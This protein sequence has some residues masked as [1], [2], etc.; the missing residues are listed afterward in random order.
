ML[1]IERHRRILESLEREGSARVVDLAREYEVTEETIRRDLDRLENAGRLQRSHGGA[2]PISGEERETPYWW[3]EVAHESEKVAMAQEAV[4]RVAPGDRILLDA[5]STAWHMARRLPDEEITVVT[6]SMRVAAA[7]S[8]LRRPEVLVLGG[9]L[10]RTSLSLVGPAAEQALEHY[11]VDRLFMSCRGLDLERG[12]S[13]STET[14]ASLR[15]CMQERADWRCLLIDHSKI[16]M[17]SLA[18]IGGLERIDEVI[19]DHQTDT[20][21]VAALEGMGIRTTVV[22]ATEKAR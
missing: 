1:A 21:T 13:D 6:N 14:Q 9:A 10:S 7:L 18:R 8:K 11:H 5:S 17:R 3:R 22:A 2:V 16:G 4:T 15:R 19:M 12:L 20:E